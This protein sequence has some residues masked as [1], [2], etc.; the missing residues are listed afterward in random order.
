MFARSTISGLPA[1][2]VFAAHDANSVGGTPAPV[3]NATTADAQTSASADTVA[4]TFVRGFVAQYKA[5]GDLRPR[6]SML[7]QWHNPELDILSKFV[8]AADE[9]GRT[10]DFNDD[11]ALFSSALATAV[12]T[13]NT[14]AA[15]LCMGFVYPEATC[16]LGSQMFMEGFR[17]GQAYYYRCPSDG[18]LAAKKLGLYLFVAAFLAGMY[19]VFEGQP[20]QMLAPVVDFIERH[21]AAFNYGQL[22]M[23]G[24]GLL[25][26]FKTG[27]FAKI[28][29]LPKKLITNGTFALHRNPF[30]ASA[31][32]VIM[33]TY[34]QTSIVDVASGKTAPW[35]AFAGVLGLGIFLGETHVAVRRDEKSLERQFGQEYLDYKKKTPRYFPAIWKPFVWAWNR[36]FHR[37]K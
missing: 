34:V 3:E 22:S 25:T 4:A 9:E 18:M 33:E 1:T 12:K 37:T 2:A 27:L 21:G 19:G 30:W 6:R 15:G 17:H 11:P 7:A 32:A 10:P 28:T 20:V 16:N 24:Y 13:S 14:R 31:G 29:V 8:Y 5:A 26:M 36:V 23:L 35:V